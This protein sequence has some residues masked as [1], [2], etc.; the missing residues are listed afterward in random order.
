VA[1]L[2]ENLLLILI[3]LELPHLVQET[4]PG[5]LGRW[6]LLSAAVSLVVILLR[7]AIVLPSLFFRTAFA[8]KGAGQV[9]FK[10]VALVGWIGMRGAESVAIA[11]ALPHLT[12][13]GVAFPARAPIIFVTFG[14]VFATLV[15][16]GV[17]IGPLTRWL[18]FQRD[19]RSEREEAHARHVVASAGLERLEELVGNGDHTSEMAKEL[20]HRS[21]S[22]ARRWKTRERRLRDGPDSG[23]DREVEVHASG[24]RRLRAAMIEAERRAVVR[25]RDQ[26][27]I[28]AE[29][30][31]RLQRDLDLEAVLLEG[32]PQ[33]GE[34]PG[35]STRAQ[36]E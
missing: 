34:Q 36:N 27:V 30:L 25:L 8:R 11:L 28:D 32:P 14:V 16:Q 2:L 6:V 19:F 10:D 3:G 35:A 23:D 9:G 12:G 33:P 4:H 22:R 7:L 20:R 13:A 5:S 31:R 18:G 29:V 26:G 24:Y 21:Q 17:S 1:F 15:L